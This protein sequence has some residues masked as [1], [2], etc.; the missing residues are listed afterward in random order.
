MQAKLK[1]LGGNPKFADN[2]ASEPYNLSRPLE[3]GIIFST[4]SHSIQVMAFPAKLT[5][6]K[7]NGNSFLE[8]YNCVPMAIVRYI[9]LYGKYI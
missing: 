5:G 3:G 2:K 4:Q 7:E 1:R 8:Y 6:Y 9:V